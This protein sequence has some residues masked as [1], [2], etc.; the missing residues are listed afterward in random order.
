MATAE[1]LVCETTE[2]TQWTRAMASAATTVAGVLSAKQ[3]VHSHASKTTFSRR[4]I[5]TTG[6]IRHDWFHGAIRM[7]HSLRSIGMCDELRRLRGTE[8]MFGLGSGSIARLGGLGR[9]LPLRNTSRKL[10]VVVF[11]TCAIP[12]RNPTRG[13][14]RRSKRGTFGL[15]RGRARHGRSGC[16][17]GT[18]KVVCMWRSRR[19]EVARGGVHR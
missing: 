4:T 17:V 16:A 11:L 14:R 8:N 18:G 6:A 15:G 2:V 13:Q 7:A 10:N 5:Y 12:L 19:G 3:S 1:E 9:N